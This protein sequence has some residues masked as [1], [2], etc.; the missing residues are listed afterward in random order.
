MDAIEDPEMRKVAALVFGPSELTRPL[1]APPGTPK[2]RAA[3][4]RKALLETAKD[5]ATIAAGAKMQM[6]LQPKTGAEVEKMIAAFQA[7]SPDLVK[8]AYA[9]THNE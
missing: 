2:D 6:T 5:P 3:A 4:L 1:A 7:T 8:K 9:Y